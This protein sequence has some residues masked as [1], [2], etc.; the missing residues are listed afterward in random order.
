MLSSV[1]SVT[2]L[3]SVGIRGGALGGRLRREIR[4]QG[5]MM[6]KWKDNFELRN[7]K[8]NPVNSKQLA[9]PRRQENGR[10][11]I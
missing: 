11:A 1:L 9:N 4:N 2:R 7:D 6:G 5:Q 8:L 3:D 10:G